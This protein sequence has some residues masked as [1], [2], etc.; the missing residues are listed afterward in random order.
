MGDFSNAIVQTGMDIVQIASV[1]SQEI[2]DV[3]KQDCWS[4]YEIINTDLLKDVKNGIQYERTLSHA[5][6]QTG[7]SVLENSLTQTRSCFQKLV[8]PPSVEK[9]IN[10]E[11]SLRRGNQDEEYIENKFTT[12]RDVQAVEV[13][14]HTGARVPIV[15][16]EQHGQK[17]SI[18][19][20]GVDELQQFLNQD[21]DPVAYREK[22]IKKLQDMY[23]D[24]YQN[25]SYDENFEYNICPLQED[26][27]YIEM[28][29]P[30]EQYQNNYQNYDYQNR[31]LNQSN[32]QHS[33]YNQQPNN[34]KSNN[35]KTTIQ[36]PNQ[37][38]NFV[39]PTF[40]PEIPDVPD[41][42]ETNKQF[43]ANGEVYDQSDFEVFQ[44]N[45]CGVRANFDFNKCLC[46]NCA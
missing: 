18:F 4:Q 34:N 2:K 23:A 17:E 24:P 6:T 14:D 43:F 15:K 22:Q 44:N 25:D 46:N 10:T 40:I 27:Q 38:T 11:L 19:A 36:Q 13:G 26:N 28:Q 21:L 29:E 32:N 8:I 35:Q 7:L 20:P 33:N 41:V 1:I 3:Q 45:Y 9:C 39:P 5:E 30:S 12:Y 16:K 37:A 42:P 31:N